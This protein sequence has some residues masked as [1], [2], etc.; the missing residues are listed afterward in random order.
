MVLHLGGADRPDPP[1]HRA[2][3]SCLAKLARPECPY[4]TRP[5]EPHVAGAL[6]EYRGPPA[7]PFVAWTPPPVVVYQIQTQASSQLSALMCL[8][9]LLLCMIVF[10]VLALMRLRS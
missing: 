6:E 8:L 10:M 4:C 3:L 7:R 5:F 9:L 2:C 1:D